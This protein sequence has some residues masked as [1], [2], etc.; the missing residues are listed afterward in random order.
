M[1]ARRIEVIDIDPGGFANFSNVFPRLSAR[2]YQA[3][4]WHEEGNPRRLL[5]NGRDTRVGSSH[6]QL[7]QDLCSPKSD[8]ET[9]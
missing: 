6:G 8:S 2:R 5:I 4:L 1:I 3:V 7:R 9:G